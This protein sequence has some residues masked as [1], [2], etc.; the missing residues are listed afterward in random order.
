VKADMDFF[1]KRPINKNIPIPL[2]YQLKEILLE[3]TKLYSVG[4]FLPTEKQLCERYG[5]SRP[6][7][8]QA[9]RELQVGGNVIQVKGK[10]TYIADPKINKEFLIDFEGFEKE[11]NLSDCVT[12]AKLLELKTTNCD[13]KSC[14]M[15]KIPNGTD[16]YILRRLIYE[17][18]TPM[19]L[20]L[21]NLPYKLFP[22]F[23]TMDFVNKSLGD[24]ITKDYGYKIRKVTK[25]IEA[26]IVSDYEAKLLKV[27]K[28]S[29]VQYLETLSFLDDETPLELTMERYRADKSKFSFTM[30]SINI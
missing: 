8:H 22:E 11:K 26:K 23:E 7:V 17:N 16:I 15:L 2:Y 18:E 20:A 28:N 10:G 27:E 25:V 6:T 5:L 12:K 3:Y 9:I 21:S 19:V 14:Q 1:L 4:T 29:P 30:S 13:G 24:I